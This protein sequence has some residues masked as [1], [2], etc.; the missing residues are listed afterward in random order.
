MFSGVKYDF[1]PILDCD[2]S[3]PHHEGEIVTS[4]RGK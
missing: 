2:D 3:F 1:L 4:Y